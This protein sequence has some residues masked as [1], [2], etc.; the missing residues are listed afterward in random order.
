MDALNMYDME[1][2]FKWFEENRDSIIADHHN[3][4]AL[5]Q[6]HKVV[7]YYKTDTNAITHMKPTPIGNFIV[8]PCLTAEEEVNFY[9]TGRF[10][11]S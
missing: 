9:Y 8:Q 1:D 7:G 11:F 2:D 6:N 3:E 10:A 4:Y 5:I